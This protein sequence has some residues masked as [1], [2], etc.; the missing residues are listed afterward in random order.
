M[1]IPEH[2][3]AIDKLDAQIV[4]LLNERTRHVLEI[5]AIKLKAGEEI[6]APHRERAV[7]QR[8]IRRNRGPITAESLRAIYREIMS[9]ALSLEKSMTIAY[10]GPEATYTHQAAIRRFG[11][12]LRYAAQ[13]TI[14]DVF[15]EVS[16]NR[17]DYGVVP[18]ENSTEGIVTHTLDMFVDSDLKI[19]AQIVVPVQ[20]CLASKGDC[21]RIQR[22]YVHPQALAQCRS[23]V[24]QHLPDAEVIETSSN[25]R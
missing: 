10:L 18:V 13:K 25:A 5:G 3:K 4:K 14:A 15:L 12:S 11:A 1:T 16:Q 7:I 24:Q 17:A 19:V 22:L 23:W 8:L 20:Y 2:R 6:Y 21:K 9:S